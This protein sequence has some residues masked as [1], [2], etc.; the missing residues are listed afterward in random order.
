MPSLIRYGGLAGLY[1]VNVT[2]VY[3]SL[4]LESNK[5]NPV[6]RLF[7][8]NSLHD[9]FDGGGQICMI[10]R[11]DSVVTLKCENMVYLSPNDN[12]RFKTYLNFYASID[13]FYSNNAQDSSLDSSK[14]LISQFKFTATYLGALQEFETQLDIPGDDPVFI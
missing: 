2:L 14:F 6:I 12:L 13:D 10:S 8:N 11:T 4:V 5:L 9:D 1:R 7:V 3:R